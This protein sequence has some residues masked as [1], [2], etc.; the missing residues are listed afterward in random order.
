MGIG[1]YNVYDNTVDYQDYW[2]VAA[3]PLPNNTTNVERCGC[4]ILK[5]R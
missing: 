2:V 5:K 4:Y 3:S 1:N